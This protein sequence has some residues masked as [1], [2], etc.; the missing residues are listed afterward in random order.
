M[1]K[2]LREFCVVSFIALKPVGPPRII[3][4]SISKVLVPSNKNML[5]VQ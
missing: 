2:K 4:I 5:F 1:D 3:I